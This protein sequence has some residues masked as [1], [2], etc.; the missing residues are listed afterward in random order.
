MDACLEIM[1]TENNFEIV[2]ILCVHLEKS[3][4]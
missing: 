2:E 3:C 1:E 4:L